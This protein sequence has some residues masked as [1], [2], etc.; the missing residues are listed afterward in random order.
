MFCISAINALFFYFFKKL[1]LTGCKIETDRLPGF[2]HLFS[3]GVGKM[4]YM[5]K[6]I[7][8]CRRHK[9]HTALDLEGNMGALFGRIVTYNIESFTFFIVEAGNNKRRTRRGLYIDNASERFK[10]R[11]TAKRLYGMV[12]FIN[13]ESIYY[14]TA[15]IIEYTINLS[16]PAK[17]LSSVTQLIY[18]SVAVVVPYTR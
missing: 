16:E 15:V 12:A 7:S 1:K 9:L 4:V 11:H 14:F 13:S 18:G 8:V 17:L 2:N 6:R 3:D 10:H 5:L